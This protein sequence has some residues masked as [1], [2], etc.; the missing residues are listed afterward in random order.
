M[1]KNVNIVSES[2]IAYL[3]RNYEVITPMSYIEPSTNELVHVS[4][5]FDIFKNDEYEISL[6][7]LTSLGMFQISLYIIKAED[8]IYPLDDVWLKINSS[9]SLR[10]LICLAQLYYQHKFLIH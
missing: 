7:Y 8:I 4:E 5:I 10:D 2:V 1:V 6:N 9:D 3:R